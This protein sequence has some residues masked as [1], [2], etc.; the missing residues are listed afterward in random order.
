MCESDD[1]S[2]NEGDAAT[3]AGRTSTTTS[4]TTSSSQISTPEN[5][6][7]ASRQ[8][9]PTA[10]SSAPAASTSTSTAA[11]AAAAK[12]AGGKSPT[13]AAP[14][15]AAAPFAA[16]RD[17]HSGR[18]KDVSLLLAGDESLDRQTLITAA[19][20][21]SRQRRKEEERLALEAAAARE[22]TRNKRGKAA[23]KS[24]ALKAKKMQSNAANR[25]TDTEAGKRRFLVGGQADV[26]YT[27]DVTDDVNKAAGKP[28]DLPQHFSNLPP[29]NTELTTSRWEDD[30]LYDS[31]DD[32]AP[33]KDL[34]ASASASAA[35]GAGA[36]ASSSSASAAAAAGGAS[37]LLSTQPRKRHQPGMVTLDLNDPQMLYDFAV[38]RPRRRIQYVLQQNK[39]RKRI[40]DWKLDEMAHALARRDTRF[41]TDDKYNISNDHF[42]SANHE[43]PYH[44]SNMM[45]DTPAQHADPALNLDERF[46]PSHLTPR[47]SAW[48]WWWWWCVCVF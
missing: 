29:L 9:S 5:S 42:Y 35:A 41:I 27:V 48:W 46:Y 34:A 43:N 44:W 11:K 45:S 25:N 23:S 22:A 10:T 12:A 39:G 14:A 3:P 26:T 19:E 16:A 33:S 2:D 31:S 32:E 21:L 47:S 36:G 18:D 38:S 8:H 17:R 1:S 20:E 24:A 7:A 13:T 15:T 28:M 6:T 4:T 37:S 30:V 40:P